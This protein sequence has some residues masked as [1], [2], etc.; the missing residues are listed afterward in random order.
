MLG[1]LNEYIEGDRKRYFGG[2]YVAKLTGTGEV[3]RIDLPPILPLSSQDIFN[4]LAA[5]SGWTQIS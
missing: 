4:S 1:P 3:F 5:I 2:I